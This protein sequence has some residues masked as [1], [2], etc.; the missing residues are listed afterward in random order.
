MSK[1]ANIQE[2]I[3]ESL[4]STKMNDFDFIKTT[5]N[6]SNKERLLGHRYTILENFVNSLKINYRGIWKLLGAHL[7]QAHNFFVH[8]PTHS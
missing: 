6:I 8:F 7:M 1:L 3:L 4:I 2:Q 5:S